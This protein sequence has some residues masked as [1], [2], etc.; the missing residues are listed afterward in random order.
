[1]IQGACIFDSPGPLIEIT[2]SKR[3]ININ[4]ITWNIKVT[5]RG[6]IK[7]TILN[8]NGNISTLGAGLKETI[9]KRP[10]GFGLIKVIININAPGIEPIEKIVKGFIFLRFIR[11]RRFL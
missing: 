11:L 6:I 7:R 8:Q 3:S 1:M 9:I 4:D 10:F 5:R 2:L